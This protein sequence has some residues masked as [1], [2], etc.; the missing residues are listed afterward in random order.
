MEVPQNQILHLHQT[1]LH[2]KWSYRCERIL[3]S[4][5]GLISVLDR[6]YIRTHV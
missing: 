2:R 1:D 3:R 6:N 5:W 4:T